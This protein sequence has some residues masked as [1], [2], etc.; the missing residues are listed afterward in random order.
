MAVSSAKLMFEIK[1]CDRVSTVLREIPLK[2]MRSL[3]YLPKA[4]GTGS[5]RLNDFE[6]QNH[7]LTELTLNEYI[8]HY[9]QTLITLRI[10]G[11]IL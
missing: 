3:G 5:V 7:S 4:F 10:R 9:G 6:N 11:A 2:S 8:G 1:A